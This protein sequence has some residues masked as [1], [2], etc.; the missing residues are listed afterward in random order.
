[1]FTVDG[2]FYNAWFSDGLSLNAWHSKVTVSGQSITRIVAEAVFVKRVS[3]PF[4]LSW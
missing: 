4:H 2:F 3:F 1:M